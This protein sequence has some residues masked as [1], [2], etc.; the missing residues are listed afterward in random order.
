RVQRWRRRGRHPR[1][2]RRIR[3]RTGRQ[4]RVHPH[5]QRQDHTARQ[6]PPAGN[7]GRGQGVT[8]RGVRA[9]T[10]ALVALI[11]FGALTLVFRPSRPGAA[12]GDLPPSNRAALEKMF[13]DDLKPLGLRVSRGL[14]QN[15]DA[16][17]EDPHG[18]HLALYLTPTSSKYVTADYV[19]NFAR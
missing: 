10:S 2:Q 19:H 14:L 16:Y 13:R 1:Q 12:S 5:V 4:P 9:A 8:R 3:A 18:T 7:A 6:G 17:K 15:L 11:A